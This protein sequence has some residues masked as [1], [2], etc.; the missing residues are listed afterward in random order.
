MANLPPFIKLLPLAG[1]LLA[2]TPLARYKIPPLIVPL[3]GSRPTL[4]LK[5]NLPPSSVS[6]K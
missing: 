4:S 2:G 3:A 5:Y 6:Q 1:T